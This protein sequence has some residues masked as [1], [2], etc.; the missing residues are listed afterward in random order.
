MALPLRAVRLLS[1]VQSAR[2]AS[3]TVAGF[4]E[5]ALQTYDIFVAKPLPRRFVDVVDVEL[6]RGVADE[7]LQHVVK[8]IAPAL[9]GFRPRARRR[10]ARIS[11]AAAWCARDCR[12]PGPPDAWSDRRWRRR[13]PCAQGSAGSAWRRG[14]QAIRWTAQLRVVRHGATPPRSWAARSA[15]SAP[16]QSA[17]DPRH[18][19]RSRSASP[20]ASFRRRCAPAASGSGCNSAGGEHVGRDRFLDRRLDGPAAFAG[21]LHEA[22]EL[23]QLRI[24]RQ[25]SGAEIEQPGG[26]H[27]AAPPDFGDV[28]QV[29]REA[30]V[31]AAD[32][33]ESLL[34]RMSKP[35]A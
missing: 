34:R 33:S 8:V 5:I 19:R 17:P 12:A 13:S 23:L 27:A 30:L 6:R 15:A 29:E 26:D 25:R 11:P 20:R 18:G 9:G 22:G 21:I 16:D 1:I 3:R 24:F 7:A 4:V 31:L 28:G 32:P 35:S 14:G 2:G 10:S